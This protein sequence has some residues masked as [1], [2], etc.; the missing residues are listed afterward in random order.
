ML[1]FFGPIASP[2]AGHAFAQVAETM[3]ESSMLFE[4]G[5]FT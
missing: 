5:F 2:N 4:R 1:R 3:K